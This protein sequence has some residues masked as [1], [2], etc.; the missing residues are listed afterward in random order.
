MFW[1]TFA[2]AFLTMAGL[3]FHKTLDYPQSTIGA[4]LTLIGIVCLAIAF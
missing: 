4:V 3:G 1:L 2:D